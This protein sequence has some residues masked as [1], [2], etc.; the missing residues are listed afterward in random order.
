ML[1]GGRYDVTTVG[2]ER[3]DVAGSFGPNGSSAPANVNGKGFT[4]ARVDTGKFRITFTDVGSALDCFDVSIQAADATASIVQAGDY[5]ASAK[6]IDVLVKQAGAG[7]PRGKQIPLNI[8]SARLPTRTKNI[9]LASAG[10]LTLGST[11]PTVNATVG[12][13]AFDADAETAYLQFKVPADWDGASDITLNL[14]WHPEAG[15]ALALNETV[16]WETDYRCI[17]S[18]QAVDNGSAVQLDTTYTESSDPGTDKV[19]IRTS[20]TLDYDHADQPLAA[21]DTVYL[22]LSRDMTTDTYA[23]DA[24]FQRFELQYQTPLALVSA[25]D[26]TSDGPYLERV[27]GATDPSWRIVWPAGDVTPIQLQAVGWPPDLDAT[28]DVTVH[29]RAGMSGATDTPVVAVAAYEE[30]GDT[31]FG[32]NSGALSSS[33]AE[34]T[35]TLANADI[36]GHPRTLNLLLTPGAHSTDAVRLYSAWLEYTST[37]SPDAFAAADLTADDNARVHFLARFRNTSIPY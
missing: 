12:G 26:D 22:A 25:A 23:A 16:I 32:G 7:T 30:L 24:V 29:L 5:D 11:P 36:A 6:T 13:L 17:A 18:G 31:D 8:L 9:P 20:I 35:R 3:V 10:N 34:V 37:E 19:E 4:V 33:V 1:I 28:A 14:V 27:N 15:T 2:P 21:G